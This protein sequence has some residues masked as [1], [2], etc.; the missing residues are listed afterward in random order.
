MNFNLILGLL[1]GVWVVGDGVIARSAKPVLFFDLHA[2]V[3]VGFGT[4]AAALIA[5]PPGRLKA[6]AK[7]IVTGA[8]FR[9]E[10]SKSYLIRTLIS[11]HAH[12]LKAGSTRVVISEDI[13]P[14]LKEGIDLIREGHLSVDEL[15]E[16]LELRVNH[17]R[18][19]YGEDAKSIA[20]IAKFPPAFGLLGAA[21]GMISLMSQL[22]SGGKESIGPAMA[23]AM[24]ATFWGVGVANFVLL[25]LSDYANRLGIEDVELRNLMVEGLLLIH[26]RENPVVLKEKL[27]SFLRL[28]EREEIE[29]HFEAQFPTPARETGIHLRSG[30]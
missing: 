23:T 11:A 26:R 25:P 22:G 7:F 9:R 30:S 15:K 17:F 13:H 19:S 20:A 8:L 27:M 2:L 29:S 5:S 14:F 28:N 1:I 24:V 12:I 4:V 16:V 6:I 3:I 21:S 18:R 10:R